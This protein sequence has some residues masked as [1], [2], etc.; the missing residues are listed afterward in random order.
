MAV[1]M[2]AR[3]PSN[4]RQTTPISSVTLAWRTL[5][6]TLNLWPNSQTTGVVISFGGY[7]S[8]N[9]VFCGWLLSVGAA[10]GFF[11]LA[12]GGMRWTDVASGESAAGDSR[13]DADFI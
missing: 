2:S 13:D 4:S 6:T 11:F 3:C 8:H 1:L 7:I 9:R 12:L 5:V 10:A